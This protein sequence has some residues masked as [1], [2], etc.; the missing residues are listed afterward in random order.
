AESHLPTER[1]DV[2]KAFA[3]TLE[4]GAGAGPSM[5]PQ[6]AMRLGLRIVKGLSEAAAKRL[7][8]AR[9]RLSSEVTG[10]ESRT[11]NSGLSFSNHEPRITNHGFFERLAHT[12]TLNRH[13]MNALAAAGALASIIGHRRQAVWTVT[14]VETKPPVLEDAPILDITPALSPPSE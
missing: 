8:E 13:D 7:V 3:D 4:H 10:H 11:T 9:R 6:P 14:G 2:S 12:A 5:N 1:L